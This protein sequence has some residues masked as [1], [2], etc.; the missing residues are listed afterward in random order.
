MILTTKRC[1]KKTIGNARLVYEELL[2]SV[3]EVEMTLNFRPLSYVSSEDVA[4][5]LC[6]YRVL[7]LPDLM[8][9][10]VLVTS[11]SCMTRGLWKLGKAEKLIPGTDSNVRCAVVK[12]ASKGQ[13]SVTLKRPVQRLYPLEFKG[14]KVSSSMTKGQKRLSLTDDDSPPALPPPE[15]IVKTTEPLARAV[16]RPRR[17]AQDTRRAWSSDLRSD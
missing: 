1:L 5:L 12:V 17:Q 10:E 13:H 8:S 6:G 2:T 11:S 14:Q 4:D 3:V 15:P 9:N 16:Q 7:S